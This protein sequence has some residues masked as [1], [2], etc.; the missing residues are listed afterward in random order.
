MD[1]HKELSSRE[2]SKYNIGLRR[3]GTIEF[4]GKVAEGLA[5]LYE[6]G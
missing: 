6:K 2:I 4:L 5:F 3:K 1:T